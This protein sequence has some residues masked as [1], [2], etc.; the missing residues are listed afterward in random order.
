MGGKISKQ[1]SAFS[2]H[3]K[4]AAASNQGSNLNDQNP[5]EWALSFAVSVASLQIV[6]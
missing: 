3:H 6:L 2:L 1:S 4:N 5:N